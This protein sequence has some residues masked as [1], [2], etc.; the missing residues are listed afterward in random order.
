MLRRV[1]TDERPHQP[2]ELAS[3]A[4]EHIV[5]ALAESEFDGSLLPRDHPKWAKDAF[6][7]SQRARELIARLRP[8][9]IRVL[10]F[11]DHRIRTALVGGRRV[12]VDAAGS[13]RLD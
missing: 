5:P 13:Y 7:I 11:W 8:V 6:T 4:P 3:A 12:N 10:T 9:V 1:E 2:H